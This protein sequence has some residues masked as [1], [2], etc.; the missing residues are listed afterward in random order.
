MQHLNHRR[1]LGSPIEADPATEISGTCNFPVYP[2]SP[3][4][5]EF[6]QDL[7][8]CYDGPKGHREGLELDHWSPAAK[9]NR[10][11]QQEIVYIFF[12]GEEPCW[13]G[14]DLIP[15]AGLQIQMVKEG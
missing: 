3:P 15:P 13:L 5:A 4:K 11:V 12:L 6:S 1:N 10:L 8:D 7:P 2:G 9:H 14:P